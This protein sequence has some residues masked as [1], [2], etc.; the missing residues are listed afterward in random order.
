[1][2]AA[3][4]N[5]MIAGTFLAI[6]SPVSTGTRRSQGEILKVPARSFENPAATASDGASCRILTTRKIIREMINEGTVVTIMNR[7]CVNRGV[8]AD[9]EARTVVSDNGDTLS[10][11]YAPEIIA[12]AI[13]PGLYPCA[14]PIPTRATPTV[15]IVV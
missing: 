13:H 9:D 6:R 12:P 14:V 4:N 11:K 5:V 7:I 8:P 1:M 15:A 2:T 3:E 10:P